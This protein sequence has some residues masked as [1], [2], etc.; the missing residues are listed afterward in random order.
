M[1]NP[2]AKTFIAAMLIYVGACAS[3]SAADKA[4][5][6]AIADPKPGHAQ[7]VFMRSSTVNMLVSTDVYDVTSGKATR[8]GK[9]SNNRK[10]V[11]D[12]PPGDYTLMVGNIPFLDFMKASV[13]PDKR[14][15]VIVAPHWPAN[16]SPNPIRQQGSEFTY[17]SPDFARLLKKTRLADP[18]EPMDEKE[19]KK[20]AEFQQVQWEKWQTKTPEQKAELTLRAEDSAQ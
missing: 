19:A 10:V 1:I 20:V 2:R 18:P 4:D 14:Y 3:A 9:L 16:F 11:L 15:F 5:K 13:L 12:L 6:T 7:V 17:S 8:I